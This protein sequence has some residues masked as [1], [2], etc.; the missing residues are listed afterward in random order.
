MQI[1]PQSS[2]FIKFDDPP[3]FN[4]SGLNGEQDEDLQVYHL[5]VE[6]IGRNQRVE[7]VGQQYLEPSII[8]KD[9]FSYKKEA[10]KGV[11]FHCIEEHNDAHGSKVRNLFEVDRMSYLM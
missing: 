6:P 8:E 2:Y 1:N 3:I 9:A 11:V 5:G 7:Y 10:Y 4:E